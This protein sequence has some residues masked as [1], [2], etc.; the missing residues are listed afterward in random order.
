MATFSYFDFD[1]TLVP[2][3]MHQTSFYFITSLPNFFQKVWKLILWA[4]CLPLFP[5]IDFF[6]SEFYTVPLIA[7]ISLSGVSASDAKLAVEKGVSP[8]LRRVCR[9]SLLN[10]IEKT[11]STNT[12]NSDG[13]SSSQTSTKSKNTVI[14]TGSLDIFMKDLCDSL[15]CDCVSSVAELDE[16]TQTFTGRMIGKAMVRSEKA[17]YLKQKHSQEQLKTSVVG[18]GNSSNDFDFLSLVSK[19]FAVTPSSNLRNLATKHGWEEKYFTIDE[20]DYHKKT[21]MLGLWM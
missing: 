16:K 13:Q 10:E 11:Q 7:W 8:K 6:L 17:R 9:P 14:I 15:G 12:N 3:D 4:I 2:T 19:P 18:Y 1:G 20:S 5:I 21:G